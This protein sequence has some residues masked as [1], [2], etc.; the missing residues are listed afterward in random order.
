MCILHPTRRHVLVVTE[1]GHLPGRLFLTQMTTI[2]DPSQLTAY[3][4]TNTKVG[5]S[6]HAGGAVCGSMIGVYSRE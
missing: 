3:L 1:G 5:G 6:S 2:I 4:N